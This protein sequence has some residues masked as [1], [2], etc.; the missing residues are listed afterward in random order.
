MGARDRNTLFRAFVYST[1]CYISKEGIICKYLI[2]VFAEKEYL[3]NMCIG[4]YVY[5]RLY[6]Q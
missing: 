6:L 5:L 4:G 1:D 2:R 3:R